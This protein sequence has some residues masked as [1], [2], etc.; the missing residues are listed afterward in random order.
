[1]NKRGAYFFVID[2]FVGASIIFLSLI[3][4]FTS[5]SII[6]ETS[7]TLRAMADYTGFLMNTKI[8]QFQGDYVE[9]LINDSN[10][11]DR[12]NTLLDQLT[13]FYYRNQTGENTLVMMANFTKEVSKGIVPEQRGLAV[14]L[15][16]SLIYN[17]T[18]KLMQQ[19][20]LVLSSQKLTFKRI[21][22]TYIYG[23]IILEVRIWI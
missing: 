8:R 21:N 10:I 7:P 12:D 16:N 1:M 17:S 9:Q 5:Y 13:E 22:E 4:I 23:P 15:N 18:P 20:N 11:T 3:I 6:P 19:S 14:Y 2:A